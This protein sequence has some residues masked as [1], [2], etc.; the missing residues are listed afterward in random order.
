MVCRNLALQSSQVAGLFN[1]HFSVFTAH[2][3]Q[4]LWTASLS[5]VAWVV[6]VG[7][8]RAPSGHAAQ[9]NRVTRMDHG[10]PICLRLIVKGHRLRS[11]EH[12]L[13]KVY[14]LLQPPVV[15][16]IP[17]TIKGVYKEGVI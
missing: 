10:C 7:E 2:A 4:A 3:W 9:C 13:G 17:I 5:M 6:K 15:L 14:G 8:M 12:E 1:G 16:P 11:A